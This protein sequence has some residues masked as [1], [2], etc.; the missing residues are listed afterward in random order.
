MWRANADRYALLGDFVGYE[1]T[2][3]GGGTVR[4]W[5]PTVQ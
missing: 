4:H 3:R 1:P 5:L 2:R